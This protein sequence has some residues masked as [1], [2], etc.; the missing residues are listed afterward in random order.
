MTSAKSSC[1]VCAEPL[2]ARAEAFCGECGNTYHLNQTQGPGK[3]CGEVWINEEHMGLEFACNRCLHPEPPAA[4]LDD[5][6]DADEAAVAAGVGLAS[7]I[8]AADGGQIRHRKTAGGVY[9]FERRDLAA[10]RDA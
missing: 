2:D 1:S 5:I 8:A 9:L 10:L 4:N 7:L 6:L 3:D